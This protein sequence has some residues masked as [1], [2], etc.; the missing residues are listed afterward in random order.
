M[1]VP[2]KASRLIAIGVCFLF[3]LTGI[4]LFMAWRGSI[5]VPNPTDSEIVRRGK[6]FLAKNAYSSGVWV[7][8]YG[9]HYKILDEGDG[10]EIDPNKEVIF[11]LRRLG[12]DG[13]D[14]FD[15]T[16][17]T[18]IKRPIDI[19]E[20]SIQDAF[21]LVGRG[22]AVQIAIPWNLRT[23]NVDVEPHGPIKPDETT[24][25]ELSVVDIAREGEVEEVKSA[26]NYPMASMLV[27]DLCGREFPDTKAAPGCWLKTLGGTQYIDP[28]C[29]PVDKKSLVE[30]GL[31][32][33]ASRS[34]DGFPQRRKMWEWVGPCLGIFVSPDIV[35]ASA[36]RIGE[37]IYGSGTGGQDWGDSYEA[38]S[39]LDENKNGWL[40]GEELNRVAIWRD[41]DSDGKPEAKEILKSSDLISK[42]KV[43]PLRHGSL[44]SWCEGDGVFFKDNTQSSTWCKITRGVD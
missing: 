27:A 36:D 18:F 29:R 13:E 35:N 32:G 8:P 22:G 34:T 25:W 16:G 12:L 31:Y 19:S 33:S 43:V 40:E 24:L 11:S 23:S 28:Y 6:E 4:A 15:G 3:I 26:L 44:E 39:Y 21:A 17:G 42:V 1:A 9:A 38:I 5:Q 41:D 10:Q 20:K 7:S 14:L 37:F 2:L 30:V